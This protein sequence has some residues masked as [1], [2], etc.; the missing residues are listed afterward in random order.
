[1]ATKFSTILNNY[2]KASREAESSNLSNTGKKDFKSILSDYTTASAI[3][4]AQR[5][6]E[7]QT[8]L[9]NAYNTINKDQQS[10]YKRTI[11]EYLKQSRPVAQT[12]GNISAA[13]TAMNG[14]NIIEIG[15]SAIKGASKVANAIVGNT[16]SNLWTPTQKEYKGVIE[17]EIEYQNDRNKIIDEINSRKSSNNGENT[18][19][20]DQIKGLERTLNEKYSAPAK[21]AFGYGLI[22]KQIQEDAESNIEDRYNE[23][24]RK[25]SYI[26]EID[27]RIEADDKT[28]TDDEINTYLQYKSDLYNFSEKEVTIPRDTAIAQMEV[29][30]D[31][32]KVS[33]KIYSLREKYGDK[34][35][36]DVENI[37]L[38]EKM[39]EVSN[40]QAVAMLQNAGI[41]N[42]DVSKIVD[43]YNSIKNTAKNKQIT[44]DI[45]QWTN[46]NFVTKILGSLASV[47]VNMLSGVDVAE[48]INALINNRR[49]NS[50]NFTFANVRD[51]FRQSSQDLF[52][53]TG[54]GNFLYNT[55]MS[56]ADMESLILMGNV[57]GL[58]NPSALVETVFGTSSG[59][60]AMKD[61][62][63]RGTSNGQAI[64][65]GLLAGTF[66]ALF[67]HLSLDKILKPEEI[68]NIGAK[69]LAE[70]LAKSG[71]AEGSEE[72][73]TELA[74]FLTDQ[75]INGGL[76]E[77]KQNISNYISQGMTYAEAKKKADSEFA[78]QLALSGAAGA[79][80]GMAIGGIEYGKNTA[81]ESGT[82]NGNISN[83]VM[84]IDFA[85]DA[86][87]DIAERKNAVEMATFFVDNAKETL[88][89]SHLSEKTKNVYNQLLDD[90]RSDIDFANNSL[91][92]AKAQTE[93]QTKE[94]KARIGI[95]KILASM[96]DSIIYAGNK[97][98][99][100]A[101]RIESANKAIE[102]AQNA[103]D[104]LSTRKDSAQNRRYLEIA[105][106]TKR[107]AERIIAELTQE[108]E[109]VTATQTVEQVQS[110]PETVETV[111]TVETSSQPQGDMGE[112]GT[113]E[114]NR[115]TD[116]E[117]SNP[118][119]VRAFFTLYNA[120]VNTKQDAADVLNANPEIKS[121]LPMSKISRIFF[122][123]VN[124]Y[125]NG[126]RIGRKN[127]TEVVNTDTRDAVDKAF[128]MEDGVEKY[129][130]LLEAIKTIDKTDE[131]YEE[132]K[133]TLED[134]L[135]EYADE[136]IPEVQ[137]PIETTTEAPTETTQVQ[138]TET[139]TASSDE[140]MVSTYNGE[141]KYTFSESAYRYAL[142]EQ[143][144][145]DN[146]TT[147]NIKAAVNDLFKSQD[148]ILKK[149]NGIST[150]CN[151]YV[152]ITTDTNI[153]NDEIV[154][155][156]SEF[157]NRIPRMISDAK[158]SS[159][160]I[161]DVVPTI[162]EL[163]F[164][165]KI[166]NNRHT[167][168]YAELPSG[169]QAK[170][171]GTRDAYAVVKMNDAYV[172]AKF[173]LD[174]ISLISNGD[175]DV[176]AYTKDGRSV[177][178]LECGDNSAI[179]LPVNV[180]NT[181]NNNTSTNN[182]VQSSVEP[183]S[184]TSTRQDANIVSANDNW[185][186][187]VKTAENTQEAKSLTAIIAGAKRLLGI[188][189]RQGYVTGG[190][191]VRGQ[192]RS[193]NKGIRVRV[194]NNVETVA[195]EIGH[196][197]SDRYNLVRLRDDLPKDL[198]K[199]LKKCYKLRY[200]NEYEASKQNEEGFAE[201][202]RYFLENKDEA[203]ITFP[204][205]TEYMYSNVSEKD[206]ASLE[207]IADEV[208][209]YLA[210]A[211]SE[212]EIPI[213]DSAKDNDFRTRKER[214][215][216][217]LLNLYT[218]FVD[219]NA[220]IKKIDNAKGSNIYI[221]A[222]NSAYASNRAAQVIA[223]DVVYGI[224]GSDYV[225]TGLSQRLAKLNLKD[226]TEWYNFNKYLT[227]RCAAERIAQG[228]RC[229]S[230]DKMNTESFC[231]TEAKKLEDAN[232]DYKECAEA[233][234]EFQRKILEAYFVKTGI[235]SREVFDEWCKTTPSYVP[236][237]RVQ[238]VAGESKDS[239][240]G[241]NKNF[242]N[243]DDMFKKMT[244]SGK[245]IITPLVS[246]LNN[247]SN[248]VQTAIYNNVAQKMVNAWGNDATILESIPT[249]LKP[250]KIASSQVKSNIKPYLVDALSEFGAEAVDTIDDMFSLDVPESLT[251][252]TKGNVNT[253]KGEFSV[254]IN[255]KKQYYVCNDKHL[256]TSL[257]KLSPAK[258]GT[259]A[260]LYGKVSKFM[261]SNIT[262][263]NVIWSIFSNMPRDLLTFA[264]YNDNKNPLK[265]LPDIASTYKNQFLNKL[266]KQVDSE[267]AL[268]L[269]MG[270][271]SDSYYSA[272][273]DMAKKAIKK[274]GYSKKT[275]GSFAS[276]MVDWFS[277]VSD[278]IESGPRY[279]AFKEALARGCTPDEA[280]YI[281]REVTVNFARGGYIS[282]EIN[283]FI[284]FFNATVQ[285]TDRF[286]RWI[287]ASEYANKS[288]EE[289]ASVV[290]KRLA[291]YLSASAIFAI[292]TSLLNL[293]DD[294]DNEY[295]NLSS[296]IK[297][298]YF[299][300]PLGD[301]RYLSIPKPREIAL[302]ESLFERIIEASVGDNSNAFN[303]FYGYAADNLL[304]GFVSDIAQ[305][306]YDDNW[307]TSA[308]GSIGILGT[309][310]Y[311]VANKDF[312][313]RPIVPSSMEDYLASAQYDGST[314]RA[315]YWIAQASKF[316]DET[317]NGLSPKQIDFFLKQ[318]LGGFWKYYS[319][320]D[321]MD[322]SRRD[323][324][325]GVQN[326][327][328]KDEAYSN[329]ISNWI[330]EEASQSEKVKN[331]ITDNI[332]YAINYEKDN[333]Y[334]TFYS[335][336]SAL[337][338][339][340]GTNTSRDTLL[341][342]QNNLYEYRNM[343]ENDSYTKFINVYTDVAKQTKDTSVVPD[344]MSTSVTHNDV[345]YELNANQYIA[346]QDKY[347]STY[348]WLAMSVVNSNDSY[349]VQ[350]QKL[351]GA[352][353]IAKE[354]AKETTLRA[355]NAK[356]TDKDGNKEKYITDVASAETIDSFYLELAKCNRPTDS[357]DASSFDMN[358]KLYALDKCS[359]TD[360]D[361]KALWKYFYPKQDDF[362][363]CKKRE[364]YKKWLK[365]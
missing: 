194:E 153:T 149:D 341:A 345:K 205:I 186:Q 130:A 343:K 110:A 188:N 10:G 132:A 261:T 4:S 5:K 155:T 47:G 37:I 278:T 288:S 129:N 223:G 32:A 204:K 284:P 43:Y 7:E 50:D 144:V 275:V 235:L 220:A 158:E 206:M 146:L 247:T 156:S 36:D 333:Y 143:R 249:P 92:T 176:Y 56:I 97:K 163:R 335:R 323:I 214:V 103:I 106:N 332:D 277:L 255:G 243:C 356:G 109:S 364:S 41:D 49:I 287:S 248:I 272:D 83:A 320:L 63:E 151:G 227:L 174:T 180:R 119:V 90:I 187:Q 53:D 66:E 173:L 16:E 77:Y 127:T 357:G 325:L 1:M 62:A 202:M 222:T 93:V 76:S 20:N 262:G 69:G 237:N 286:L 304:P 365:G 102:Q 157:V 350:A 111:E 251:F 238:S 354:I 239:I 125:E 84:N 250:I 216:D 203:S 198:V 225:C 221:Y 215:K 285:G 268:Y 162:Q 121:V 219:T 87:N 124:D 340:E 160:N 38:N 33:D 311:T 6:K 136:L 344:V 269:A 280:F 189:I 170:K 224:N 240:R 213:R 303:G 283:K 15:N 339:A 22:K 164:I 321:P 117:K 13:T 141:T 307:L 217:T 196:A 322:S 81:I 80:S 192:Y 241:N 232:P 331:T 228:I 301:H 324:T 289:R 218:K 179:V 95:K 126:F 31:G 234:Y 209:A 154:T 25:R 171:I 118:A 12:V 44:K 137:E 82:V 61:A 128:D 274:M 229:F 330:Y 244:G 282:R 342:L 14:G 74:T 178:Y 363:V 59:L 193:S 208:N 298:S 253:A 265:F 259:I 167:V 258:A 70:Q 85:T 114:F 352:N 40:K 39:G 271:G 254:F 152:A 310:V 140:P 65:Q 54:V 19:N 314:S 299:N 75:L 211:P 358:E 319:A 29:L 348:E 104:V 290:K 226:K 264:T 60:S 24:A 105:N 316:G 142:S 346:Y 328:V 100:N 115:L 48:P 99:D 150:I 145:S 326:Q 168:D 306:G 79:L 166:I 3:S 35:F 67:E 355:L 135:S 8:K 169:V 361:K 313:G 96:L 138:P 139:V 295:K 42:T 317:A 91:K 327:Y 296:Y 73:A 291:G 207:V 273:S 242:V 133:Q 212:R 45:A 55:I 302:P 257:T 256:L 131:R 233:V 9:E 26:A 281:S 305:M 184:K 236:M 337:V 245:D 246:I 112:R 120:A 88:R 181:A 293:G 336:A 197:I 68:A 123:G 64:A 279:A 190:S 28:L 349:E 252:F 308:L 165:N 51:T 34:L 122:S 147:S 231:K 78:T 98:N 113:A 351:Q 230:D 46:K 267:F 17:R 329:D 270:G 183:S 182:N 185:V 134:L 195:H 101:S 334:K 23:N 300:I 177:V 21:T 148:N 86:V 52:G 318:T 71:L 2:K 315:A 201:Y 338:K 27:A 94:R 276:D 200:T 107:D 161:V 108:S 116:E 159:T 58:S 263:N 309:A 353:A 312:L 199:E 89:Y 260:D 297:N 347:Y 292:L 11:N 360:A 359:G 18:I 72:V 266:G 30:Q 362:Y 172:N 294:D 175:E 57:M 210:Q 191:R